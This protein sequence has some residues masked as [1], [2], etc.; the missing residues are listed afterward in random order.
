[1]ML[2]WTASLMAQ[3]ATAPT[4]LLKSGQPVEWWFAL[5]F[6]TESFPGSSA[7]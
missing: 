4:P 2:L 5:K 7:T 1:M 6:N 3:S